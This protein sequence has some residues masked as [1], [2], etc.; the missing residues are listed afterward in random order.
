MPN[1][2]KQHSKAPVHQYN[3][4]PAPSLLVSVC[5]CYSICFRFSHKTLLLLCFQR[6]ADFQCL[7]RLRL[8]QES[9]EYTGH[10]GRFLRASIIRACYRL[11]SFLLRLHHLRFYAL[12]QF[13][14]PVY[15][16]R[17]FCLFRYLF[18]RFPRSSDF[19]S[20]LSSYVFLFGWQTLSIFTF[21]QVSV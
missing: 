5:Y 4:E 10:C 8:L 12:N 17:S 6:L 7:L 14:G 3:Y 9:V 1:Y 11:G 20:F 21:F 15:C 19:I 16:G 13:L 18:G 2:Y